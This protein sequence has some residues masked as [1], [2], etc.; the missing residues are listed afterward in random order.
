[1]YR[2]SFLAVLALLTLA[3]R[4]V[5]AAEPELD[6]VLFVMAYNYA[7]KVSVNGV[8]A[9]VQG[10]KSENKRLFTTN[11]SM[12]VK[13]PPAIR[14]RHA[15]LKAGANEFTIEYSRSD[16]KATDQ[17]EIALHA[18]GYPQPLLRLVNRGKASDKLSLTV[19]IEKVAP[20]GFK[21]LEFGD[22]K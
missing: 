17:L 6:V 12:M 11:H 13:A 15:L 8:D 3:A 20:A 9:G 21:P 10:G 1:M 14:A 2:I 18:D 7:V 22:A 16:P 5:A 4:G 19:Q